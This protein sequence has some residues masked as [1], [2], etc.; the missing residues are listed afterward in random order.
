MINVHRIFKICLRIMVAIFFFIYNSSYTNFYRYINIIRIS[1]NL[2]AGN[3]VLN[4]SVQYNILVIW[5]T[6]YFTPWKY[7][8]Y[9]QILNYLTLFM[10]CT[11]S[12][13]FNSRF[14]NKYFL[15]FNYRNFKSIY[16]FN[17]LGTIFIPVN[18]TFLIT[19]NIFN[20]FIKTLIGRFSPLI[21]IFFFFYGK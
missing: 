17:N 14:F 1:K 4:K 10:C 8:M 11:N 19:E 7:F 21:Y 12:C 2:T 6:S 3:Y 20:I 9:L 15:F 13:M 18:N 5:I 16:Y